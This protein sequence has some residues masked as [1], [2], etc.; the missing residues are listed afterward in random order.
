[1]RHFIQTIAIVVLMLMSFKTMPAQ[2]Q[3]TKKV[4]PYYMIPKENPD[5][6]RHSVK[7]PDL[8]LFNGMIAFTS[9]RN[10]TGNYRADIRQYVDRDRLGNVIWPNYSFMFEKNVSEITDYLASRNLYLF[11]LWGFVP[12]SGPGGPWKQFTAPRKVLDMFQ[13]KLG[14][15]WLGMDNGEQDGRYIGSFASRQYPGGMDRKQQYL[16]FQHHFQGMSD[17]LGNHL[18][19]LVSLNYGHYYLKEGTYALIGAE[20]AQGLPNTQI[21]YSFI[22]GAGKQYGVSWFGNA[23][24]WNRW[25][26]KDYDP[27]TIKDDDNDYNAGSP[28]KGTSLSLL[29]RLIYNHFFY[30]CIMAGFEGSLYANGDTL[31]PIG[32]IQQNAVKWIHQN[33]LP[34]VMHTPVALLNDFFS[35]WTFP[36]HLYS[37]N[38]YRVWGS[39]PY[40]PSDYM[41]DGILDVI[42]P[43]YQDASYYHDERGFLAPTPYGDIADCLLS[44]AP[45][46]LMKR[47]PVIV[48]ADEVRNSHELHDKLEAYVQAGGHLVIT[49]GSLRHFEHG[50]CG[51]QVA[52]R[53]LTCPPSS[54]NYLQG[55]YQETDS[56]RVD[57]LVEGRDCTVLANCQGQPTILEKA[58]GQGK[59]T[60]ITIPFGV[61]QTPK[62][63]TVKIKEDSPLPTPYPLLKHVKAYLGHLFGSQALFSA[64]PELSMVTCVKDPTHYT[65]ILT[66]SQWK[67]VPMNLKS[68]V[69]KI[70]SI[71][72]LQIPDESSHAAGYV[73]KVMRGTPLGVHTKTDIAGGGVRVF[74]IRTTGKGVTMLGPSVGEPLTR[75]CALSLRETSDLQKEILLRPTFFQHYNRAVIDWKYIDR[76]DTERLKEEGDWLKRQQVRI[77]VD[78]AS[79]I[80]LFPDLRI[81]NNDPSIYEASIQKIRS[82]IAKMKLIGADEL[83]LS[84]MRPIENNFTSE[85]FDASLIETYRKL[86]DFAKE[87]GITVV[88]RPLSGTVHSDVEGSL[89]VVRDVNKDNFVYAVS[90]PMLAADREHLQQDLSLLQ[91]AGVG[92]VFVSGYQKDIN[93]KVVNYNY[94]LAKTASK[95]ELLH[96]LSSL[97]GSSYYLDGLY[98]NEN[99][100]YDDGKIIP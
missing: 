47:Y 23:S 37:G 19:T 67:Q 24:V 49:S 33:G 51:L 71:K 92:R 32:R 45:L 6:N 10:L 35:G 25:G 70:L 53:S 74:S 4:Y 46:W 60:V 52:S 18:S 93:D 41:T 86:A 12:G 1:M 77:S 91:A 13:A 5:Y 95:A 2:A 96:I 68:N 36:R 79:G 63:S 87:E 31:S 48:V 55:S 69:G 89:K 39:I 21:Y 15:R 44:D 22:R 98:Q 94:P 72:E 3:V 66:N 73:P 80:N 11:D 43:G 64:N 76:R 42:Y 99:E 88:F 97:H 8:S 81:V 26:Y 90:L 56:F 27:K 82:I 50:L 78:L 40:E 9:L 30:N 20:T 14:N 7:S 61:G 38:A 100:E 85:K 54:V 83:L 59:V 62:V 75:H 28:W 58:S 16:K 84:S 17:I 29:K 34:G 65:V 57:A